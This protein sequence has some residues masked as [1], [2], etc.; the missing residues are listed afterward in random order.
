MLVTAKLQDILTSSVKLPNNVSN[1]GPCKICM[2]SQE[3]QDIKD[4]KFLPAWKFL[5]WLMEYLGVPLM[6]K[7]PTPAD[8][9]K[10]Q[11][12]AEMTEEERKVYEKEQKKKN[13][14]KKKKDKEAE[15]LAKA[16]AERAEKRAAAR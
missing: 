5:P 8:E 15:D 2:S 14:E 4:G 9:M 3:L 16:K 7:P 1:K 11:D 13:E 6:Q 10:E 12:A